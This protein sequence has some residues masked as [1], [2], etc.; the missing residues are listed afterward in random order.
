MISQRESKGDGPANVAC[1]RLRI[2]G[3]EAGLL[4]LGLRNAKRSDD[5]DMKMCIPPYTKRQV[6]LKLPL[7]N[8]W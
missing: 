2:G 1:A 5:S 6:V 7:K 4:R 8:V 3:A